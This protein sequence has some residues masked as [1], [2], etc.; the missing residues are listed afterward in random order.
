MNKEFGKIYKF[1]PK[2]DIMKKVIC[3]IIFA[4]VSSASAYCIN[5]EYVTLNKC[6]Y[7]RFGYEYGYVETYK[8]T[9]GA[10]YRVF[11]ENRNGCDH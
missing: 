5:G 1:K 11:F 10:T 4:F 7:E 8:G 6:S 2:E 3:A 9:S